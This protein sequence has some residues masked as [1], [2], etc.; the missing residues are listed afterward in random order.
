MTLYVGSIGPVA[1]CA[2]QP[3]QETIDPLEFIA[4]V[5]DATKANRSLFFEAQS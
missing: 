5:G 2:M 1:C 3:S 4:D